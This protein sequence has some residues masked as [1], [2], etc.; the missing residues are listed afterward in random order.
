M[1]SN[2]GAD[3]DTRNPEQ[4]PSGGRL[5]SDSAESENDSYTNRFVRVRRP[6]TRAVSGASQTNGNC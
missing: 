4:W 3:P 2:S 5:T 6:R 1:R